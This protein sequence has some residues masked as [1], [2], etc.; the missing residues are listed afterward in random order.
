M[1]AE[2]TLGLEILL[3]ILA[4]IWLVLWV[5]TLIHEAKRRRYTWLAITALIQLSLVVYWVIFAF[6]NPF[7]E[8]KIL[9]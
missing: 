4:I 6:S 1:A 5:I 8:K 9:S 2:S 3:L 7:R